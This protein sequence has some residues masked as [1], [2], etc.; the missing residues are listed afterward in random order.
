MHQDAQKF[1]M[2]L[3]ISLTELIRSC[4]GQRLRLPKFKFL[5]L[6]FKNTLN[7]REKNEKFPI[8][9]YIFLLME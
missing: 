1:L 4:L 7:V 2:G 6:K 9:H 8:S 5:I 3:L